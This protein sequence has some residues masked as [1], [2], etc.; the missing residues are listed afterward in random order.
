MWGIVN[1]SAP[2]FLLKSHR[3]C[4]TAAAVFA[5]FMIGRVAFAIKHNVV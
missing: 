3:A 4:V 5:R 1:T 2:G